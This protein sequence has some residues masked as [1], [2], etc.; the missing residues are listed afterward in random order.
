MVLQIHLQT[1]D[2]P[3]FVNYYASNKIANR[4][5]TKR[6]RRNH[7]QSLQA[8][9]SIIDQ[10]HVSPSRCVRF[11]E[12]TETFEVE[13]ASVDTRDTWY[14]RAQLYLAQTDTKN[15]LARLCRGEAEDDF[16]LE[17]WVSR[18]ALKFQE[19][20]EAAMGA[21]IGDSS[22][23]AARPTQG[24]ASAYAAD[25]CIYSK[26]VAN[27]RGMKLE[28]QVRKYYSLDKVLERPSM[29]SHR[30]AS[31]PNHFSTDSTNYSKGQIMS[32]RLLLRSSFSSIDM[33]MYRRRSS[34]CQIALEEIH[35]ALV[36]VRRT[37]LH[38]MPI[39]TY[40]DEY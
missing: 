10:L 28:R 29:I 31:C 6:T 5:S 14:S 20:Q 27:T 8:I 32:H 19:H 35:T 39:A 11:S 3:T 25:V 36:S 4:M 34:R 40:D 16:G 9:G 2:S 1:V 26:M 13:Y 38:G 21:V 15:C 37:G 24:I 7:Q 30:G 17:R 12:E 33:S 22:S 18:G 23:Y